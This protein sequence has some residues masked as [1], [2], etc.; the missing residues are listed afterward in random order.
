MAQEIEIR[1]AQSVKDLQY[2]VDMQ[3]IEGWD[4]RIY[5]AESFFDADNHGFFIAFLKETNIPVGCISCVNYG[6][7]LG[8]I[9]SF[10]VEKPYRSKGYGRKLFARAMEHLGPRNGSLDSVEE[11]VS[12]YNKWGFQFSW[13]NKRYEGVSKGKNLY[14]NTYNIVPIQ[15]IAFSVL[16]QYDTDIFTA[17]RTEFLKK[18]AYNLEHIAFGALENGKLVGYT[19]MRPGASCYKIG[20]L[21]ADNNKIASDLFYSVI[22]HLKPSQKFY[23]DIPLDNIDA[24]KLVEENKMNPIFETTRMYTKSSPQFQKQKIFGITAFELG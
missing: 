19:V 22:S 20:P 23:L 1:E 11:Q 18:W 15:K 5:E 2:F 6:D 8:T 17:P 13:N 12:N 3:R 21:F 10:I 4:L 14:Q 16:E 7:I 9:G 24:I